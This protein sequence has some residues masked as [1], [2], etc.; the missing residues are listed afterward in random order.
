MTAFADET[1]PHCREAPPWTD[2]GDPAAPDFGSVY[3]WRGANG[4]AVFT[5]DRHGRRHA[6][7]LF[8]RPD[9]HAAVTIHGRRFDVAPR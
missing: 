7:T 8:R 9:P 1:A 3:V 4:A 6:L 5:F 2:C